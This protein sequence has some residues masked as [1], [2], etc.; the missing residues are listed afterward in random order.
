MEI[1]MSNDCLDTLK[2]LIS[3]CAS[4]REDAARI[5]DIEA[6]IFHGAHIEV[7]HGHNH[8]NIEIVL[9]TIHSLIPGHCAF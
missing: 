3:S 9:T 2:C 8:K 7:A 6:F 4:V 5:K 1:F